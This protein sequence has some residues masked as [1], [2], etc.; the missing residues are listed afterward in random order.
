MKSQRSSILAVPCL[1]A[2]AL[3][4]GA[5]TQAQSASDASMMDKHFVSEALKGGMAEVELGRLAEE[6]GNSNDVKEFGRKMVE[7]HTRMG[8]QMK[9]VAT[10]IGVTPPTSP[11]M[12]E[13]VEL[14]K[15]KGLSGDQFDQ[16][17][18]KAMVKDH[19]GDLKDFQKEASTGKSATVKDAANQGTSVVSGHLAM[20]KQIAQAHNL[21]VN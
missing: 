4:I 16:A 6:K 15:M 13:Q 14:K 8:D 3:F 20:I 21:S 9:G 2:A 19:E 12:M 10:Q 18:I 7:D 5:G 17:Y 11:T 1:L